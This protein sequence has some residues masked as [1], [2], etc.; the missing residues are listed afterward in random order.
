LAIAELLCIAT[1]IAAVF[2]LPRIR[3]KGASK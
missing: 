2:F 3:N 1:G